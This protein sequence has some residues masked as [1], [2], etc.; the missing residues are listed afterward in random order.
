MR[1]DESTG[2]KMGPR[3]SAIIACYG[4]ELASRLRQT[5]VAKLADA[6]EEALAEWDDLRHAFED[7]RYTPD[8]RVEISTSDLQKIK[9]M[10]AVLAEVDRG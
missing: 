6:L 10:R 1:M 3:E 5:Q 7:G 4:G 9:R 2:R 8:D